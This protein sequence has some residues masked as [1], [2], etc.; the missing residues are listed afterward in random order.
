MHD[1][2][3]SHAGPDFRAYANLE[4]GALVRQMPADTTA[5]GTHPS[6]KARLVAQLQSAFRPLGRGAVG[7][8]SSLGPDR[9]TQRAAVIGTRPVAVAIL[10]RD[11][12]VAHRQQVTAGGLERNST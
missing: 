1:T 10:A 7:A 6:S 12:T 4:R 2:C 9:A 3:S 5:G 11:A 8:P